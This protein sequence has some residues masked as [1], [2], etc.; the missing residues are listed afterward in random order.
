MTWLTWTVLGLLI[1]KIAAKL[2]L[3]NLALKSVSKRNPD[4]TY[5]A[6][7]MK[8]SLDYTRAKH[9]IEK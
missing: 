7:T 2:W 8:R 9:R 5:D 6:L 3:E 1:I 4:S